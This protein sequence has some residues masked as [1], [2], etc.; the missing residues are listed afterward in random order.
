[1]ISKLLIVPF[2]GELPEWY[3]QYQKPRGYDLLLDQDLDRFKKRVKKHLGFIP[4]IKSGTGKVQDFRCAFG[5]LYKK[6]L[7][8]Y[9]W[10]G[11][12]DLDMVYG[13]VKKW[14]PDEFLEDLDIHSNHGT[15]ICGPW[16]LYRNIPE[17]NSLFRQYPDW[18]NKMLGEQNG[19]VEME[20]SRL[21]ENSGLRYKYTF[22]QGNPWAEQFNIKKIDGKLYQ[23]NIEIPMF[24]FRHS[25]RWPIKDEEN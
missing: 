2:F 12:T 21:V 6:E 15:Y 5:E 20:Y 8:G 3:D 24:H 14:F 22:E 13:D 17:V 10:Y 11:H 19:W 23:D 25:K 7:V 1:M 4:D 9:T 18:K 16:T